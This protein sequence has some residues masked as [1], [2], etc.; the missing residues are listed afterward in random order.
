MA[1]EWIARRHELPGARTKLFCFAHA[2]GGAWVF[3]PWR[4]ALSPGIAVCPIVLPG[5]E[6]RLREPPCVRMEEF[7]APLR[8]AIAACADRPFAFFGHSLGAV[9]AYEA[10]RMLPPSKAPLLMRLFVSGRRAP[11]LPPGRPP[12]HRLGDAAFISALRGLGGTPDELLGDGAMLAL[13][14]PALRADFELN[15]TYEPLPGGRLTCP[16]TAFAG[17]GDPET[18]RAEIS[19]WRA[20]TTGA[21]GLREFGGGHFYLIDQQHELLAVIRE[22][23]A[24]DAAARA[25]AA[26]PWRL[27]SDQTGARR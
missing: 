24:A 18:S 3:A 20:V 13:F 10:A 25:D 19:G 1:A 6:S 12:L 27:L 5:R 11:Q 23:L 17:R 2:G 8:D 16:I 14:L 9:V 15:D 7:I 21:F 22:Q 4:A 26:A